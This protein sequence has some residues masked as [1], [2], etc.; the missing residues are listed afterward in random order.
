MARIQLGIDY[1]GRGF[2]PGQANHNAL[3]AASMFGRP[4][5][6]LVLPQPE[7]QA[8]AA[9]VDKDGDEDTTAVR[10]LPLTQAAGLALAAGAS[11]EI[12]FEPIRWCKILNF[13]VSD[14]LGEKCVL[15]EFFIGQDNMFPN[16]G[17]VPF[18]NYKAEATDKQRDIPWCGPGVPL[19]LT[20]KNIDAAAVVF[21]GSAR[22]I[23]IIG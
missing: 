16:K 9:D 7:F 21:Y 11:G 3:L 5:G 1:A 8:V 22:V 4:E 19:I 6:G 23:A 14:A 17:A 15:T 20:V 18:S 12:N 13:T 2:L 10:D